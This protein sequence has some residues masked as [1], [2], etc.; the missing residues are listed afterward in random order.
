MTQAQ[1]HRRRL[2]AVLRKY[3]G[4][5]G[6]QPADDQRQIVFFHLPYPGVGGGVCVSQRKLQMRGSPNISFSVKRCP[7]AKSA[8]E[9]RLRPSSCTS[10]SSKTPSPQATTTG[11]KLTIWPGDF[12][13]PCTSPLHLVFQTCIGATRKL[14]CAPGHGCRPR[15]R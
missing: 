11:F 10:R 12:S 2:H 8:A 14:V 6:R 4:R 3:G 5:I 9:I 1:A 13:P 7:L 15:T